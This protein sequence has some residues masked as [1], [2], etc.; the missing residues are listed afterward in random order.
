VDKDGYIS[1]VDLETCIKNLNSEA[2]YKN[3]GEALVGSSFSA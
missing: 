1:E 3:N 2:F